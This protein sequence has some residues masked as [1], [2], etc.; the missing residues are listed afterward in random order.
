MVITFVGLWVVFSGG[1]LSGG[2]QGVSESVG[3]QI[4]VKITGA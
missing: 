1:D 2:F 4:P 3:N